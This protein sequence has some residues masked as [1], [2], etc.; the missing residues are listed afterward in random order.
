MR[1]LIAFTVVTGKIPLVYLFLIL[2]TDYKVLALM[3]VITSLLDDSSG[4]NL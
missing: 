3:K 2:F 1:Y 4:F